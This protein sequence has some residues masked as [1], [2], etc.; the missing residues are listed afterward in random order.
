MIGDQDNCGNCWVFG[1]SY[2]INDRYC[3]NNMGILQL[4][5]QYITSCCA[6]AYR[7]NGCG[8]AQLSTAY[9]C[10]QKYGIPTGG[11]FGSNYGCQPYTIKDCP[12]GNGSND[13]AFSW[14]TGK[15]TKSSAAYTPPCSE[16]CDAGYPKQLNDDRH[17]AKSYYQLKRNNAPAI[18]AEIY[19]R[20]PVTLT[21]SV[22]QDFMNYKSG[23]YKYTSGKYIGMHAVKVFGWGL[24]NCVP[25]WLATNEWGPQWGDSGFFKILRGSN[26]CKIEAN[27]MAGIPKS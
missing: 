23:V 14:C 13:V 11:A 20:G 8:G 1:S 26:H 7:Y 18:Q 12:R 2:A 9:A 21:F 22:Y 4:S 17:F 6:R 10:W 15:S 24:E 25:Y 5:V 16:C 27:G 3:I 19:A